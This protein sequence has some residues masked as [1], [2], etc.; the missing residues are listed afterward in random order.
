MEFLSPQNCVVHYIILYE[1]IQ[2]P[3]SYKRWVHCKLAFPCAEI[4]IELYSLRHQHR[5]WQSWEE[6]FQEETFQMNVSEQ[7]LQL[8]WIVIIVPVWATLRAGFAEEHRWQ[9]WKRSRSFERNTIPLGSSLGFL[10]VQSSLWEKH[11]TKAC[12]L[13]L[14]K[15]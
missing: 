11:K 4:P 13:L 14:Y 5:V 1:G 7:R 10:P 9:C 8:D 15:H 2:V 6:G 12:K 3:A